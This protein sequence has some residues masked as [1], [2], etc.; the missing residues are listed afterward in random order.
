MQAAAVWDAKAVRA[1]LDRLEQ[2][3]DEP[4]PEWE[5]MSERLNRLEKYL[6]AKN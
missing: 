1:E 3:D 2:A 5:P 4:T 6:N